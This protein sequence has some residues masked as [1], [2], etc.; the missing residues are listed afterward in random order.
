MVCDSMHKACITLRQTKFQ[1][2]KG[3][4][5]RVPSLAEELMAIDTSW[6]RENRYFKGCGP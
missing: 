1:Q 6:E 5:H 4:G 2:R 3:G